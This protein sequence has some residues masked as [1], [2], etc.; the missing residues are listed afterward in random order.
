MISLSINKSVNSIEEL[1]NLCYDTFIGKTKAQ[2]Q[3]KCLSYKELM[4]V[5]SKRSYALWEGKVSRT[6]FEELCSTY[7][8]S[9]DENGEILKCSICLDEL[10]IGADV[11]RLPCGHLNCKTCI[12]EWF[13]I[14][15][16]N[17]D[18]YSFQ[19]S[20]EEDS[21]TSDVD[22]NDSSV[23]EDYKTSDIDD[24]DTSVEE[25]YDT[26]DIVDSDISV[27][28]ENDTSIKEDNDTL[29]KED[30]NVDIYDDYKTSENDEDKNLDEDSDIKDEA[31]Q[32]TN[33]EKDDETPRDVYWNE[34]VIIEEDQKQEARNQCPICKHICS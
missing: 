7:E 14:K 3:Q 15:T 19:T 5:V 21:E 16:E 29:V 33:F 34:Y 24:S 25:D 30:N 9:T 22:D 17:S 10:K 32:A 12:E 18:E 4:K 8:G 26:S 6:Y 2:N 1:E 13:D 23:E 28:E 27:E 31:S 20:D 11:C